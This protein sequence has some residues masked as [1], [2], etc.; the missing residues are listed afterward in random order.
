M[1]QETLGYTRTLQNKH[2]KHASNTSRR[3]SIKISLHG[4]KNKRREK[5]TLQL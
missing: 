3:Y 1:N 2:K 5:K 4:I